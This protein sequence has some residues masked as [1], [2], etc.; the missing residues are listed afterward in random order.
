M[1]GAVIN[2]NPDGN[3]RHDFSSGITSEFFTHSREKIEIVA[4]GDRAPNHFTGVQNVTIAKC[5]SW[6][7]YEKNNDEIIKNN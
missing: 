7:N 2:G 1:R 6:R 4:G 5:L 3:P